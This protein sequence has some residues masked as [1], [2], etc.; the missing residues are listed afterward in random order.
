MHLAAGLNGEI[1][2]RHDAVVVQVLAHA[3]DGVA[4]MPPGLP[5]RLKTRI[6]ASATVLRSMSTM[7]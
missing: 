6:F 1:G 2:A 7:P 5:S 4:A 3:A